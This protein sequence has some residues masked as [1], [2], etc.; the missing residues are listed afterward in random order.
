MLLEA[1]QAVAGVDNL[2]PA[3]DVRLKDWRLQRLRQYPA[4][5]FY[6]ADVS[7]QR[8]L[9]PVFAGGT[10]TAIVHLAAR[11]GIRQSV[12]DPRGYFAAN[13]DGTLNVLEGCRQGASGKL[14]LASSSSLYGASNE[15]PYR[16]DAGTSRPLSPYAASKKAAEALAYAYHHLHGLDV[17]VLRCFTVYGPAGRPDMAVFRLVRQIAEGEPV[18]LFGDGSQQR[19]FTYIDDAARGMLAALRPLGFEIINLGGNQP[20]RLDAV[21]QR[22]AALLERRPQIQRRPAQAVDLPAT[23]ADV[24]K[25][26]RL[27]E[28]Q[29]QVDLDEGLRRCVDWYRDHRE[30][31][32]ALNL[33]EA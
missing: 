20:V 29:P 13:V 18:V 27:L 6:P 7:D 24:T 23:W 2:S 10:F 4:F 1:G 8:S 26:R 11:A 25:A 12:A 15:L 28:W 30:F 21:I 5:Q 16:E 3:Y 31:A 17:S 22:I 9:E 32:R 19:D 33:G 14:V